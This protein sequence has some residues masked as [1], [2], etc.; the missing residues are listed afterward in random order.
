[1]QLPSMCQASISQPPP[2]QPNQR[3]SH[4]GI[5]LQSLSQAQ[6][7]QSQM[8]SMNSVGG[9]GALSSGYP[10]DAMAQ[11]MA[12][13]AQ[14]TQPQLQQVL[15]A[16]PPWFQKELVRRL[17]RQ[18][19]EMYVVED[20]KICHWSAICPRLHGQSQQSPSHEAKKALPVLKEAYSQS[21]H[22]MNG[23]NVVNVMSMASP[24]SACGLTSSHSHFL[25][26]S[27]SVS[28]GPH[29]DGAYSPHHQPETTSSPPHTSSLCDHPSLEAL[30]RDSV[31][32]Q[33]LSHSSLTPRALCEASTSR[34]T[35]FEI[36][37]GH[38]STD[39]EA[40]DEVHC[41]ATVAMEKEA[42][43]EDG[44]EQSKLSGS[45]AQLQVQAQAQSSAAYQKAVQRWYARQQQQQQAQAQYQQQ[46]QLHQQQQRQYMA[47]MQQAYQAKQIQQQQQQAYYAQRQQQQ[48]QPR[49]QHSQYAYNRGRNA[50]TPPRFCA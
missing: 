42:K 9:G 50:N 20:P 43:K 46:L 6:S 28:A 49:Q 47:Q 36:L 26:P 21:Q 7:Q 41:V 13:Y 35:C 34:A 23:M 15:S 27:L 11:T 32:D 3:H 29:F 25:S 16:Y 14:Y 31:T 39:N 30:D 17:R 44:G 38:I 22:G 19:E 2:T 5:V 4:S 10:M 12:Q 48:Q 18:Y 24:G 40:S 45:D 1:M 33:A 8:A 37:E